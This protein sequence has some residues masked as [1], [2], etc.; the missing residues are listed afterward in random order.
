MA[1]Q[2]EAR[3]PETGVAWYVRIDCGGT[4]TNLVLTTARRE[5]H[6]R[7][8]QACDA[9][10]SRGDCLRDSS[11]SP[12]SAALGSWEAAS[13]LSLELT[14]QWTGAEL[15]ATATAPELGT[16]PPPCYRSDDRIVDDVSVPPRRT[17]R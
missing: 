3:G 14:A 6:A 16:P 1:S 2:T 5:V 11:C 17:R 15:R 9:S 4:F 7:V 10:P 13:S 8:S 12:I